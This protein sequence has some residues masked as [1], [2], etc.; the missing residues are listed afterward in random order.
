MVG[1]AQQH[2]YLNIQDKTADYL[3]S[4]WTSCTSE[5]EDAIT[6]WNQLTMTSGLDF[7]SDLGSTDPSDLKY[8]APPGEQWYYHNAPYT[9]LQ[10]VVASAVDLDFGTYLDDE[11]LTKIGMDGQFIPSGNN[12]VFYSTPRDAARFGS[13]ILNDGKWNDVSII[14]DETFFEEMVTTSQDLNPSYGY[15]WWLNGKDV[16]HYPGVDFSVSGTLSEQAPDDL[17][18]GM[19]ANGQ[20]VDIVPSKN[21]VVIRMGQ[22]PDGG[23]VP[24]VMHDEMWGYIM[25][26]IE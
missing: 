10:S 1:I 18:A 11:L 12:S 20:F 14:Q 13:L 22:D 4:G 6:I 8:Y 26:M 3:G 17:F 25:N 24:V 15:L 23:L 5:Q 2:G 7:T 16:V 21:M 9:L 19:G